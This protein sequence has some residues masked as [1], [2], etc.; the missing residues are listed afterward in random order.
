MFILIL[1]SAFFSCT[2]TAITAMN[3]VR[4]RYLKEQGDKRAVLLD[5][6]LGKPGKLITTILAGNN[7]V[8][9]AASVLG[10]IKIYDFMLSRGLHNEILI[11]IFTTIIMTLLILMFG[12]IIPKV[13]SIHHTEFFALNSVHLIYICHKILHPFTYVLNKISTFLIILFGGKIHSKTKEVTE[14]EIKMLIDVG[15]EEGVIEK[16]EKDMIQAVFN[17]SDKVVREIMTPRTEIV[18]LKWPFT[19]EDAMKIIKEQ[20]H[21][22]IPICEGRIDNITGIIYAK[23]ILNYIQGN[24]QNDIKSLL[25]KP[26]FIPETKKISE[27]MQMM[28]KDRTHMAIVVDEYGGTHGLVT[29]EDIIE[30]IVGEVH[31]EYEEPVGP[32]MKRIDDSSYLLNGKLDLDKAAEELDIVMSGEE[33]YD[34][35]G[36]FVLGLFDKIPKEGETVSYK[37]IIFT[38]EKMND[39]R[40][41]LIKAKKG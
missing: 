13:L 29:F 9:I 26:V 8:N 39:K 7:I 30:E 37:N 27:L 6:L 32:V 5:R 28:K 18:S 19:I 14:E 24:N 41:D 33:E 4:L 10:T 23:D 3:K 36:G 21:S 35:I 11:S 2:E 31:D 12:E 1:F 16:D 38:I 22:R 40:I 20:G 17:L 15:E 34:T 25:R